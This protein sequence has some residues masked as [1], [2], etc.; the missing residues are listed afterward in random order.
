MGT[1][2]I[3][4][5]FEAMFPSLDCGLVQAIVSEAPAPERAMETLLALTAAMGEPVAGSEGSVDLDQGKPVP[6]NVHI[7]NH[8]QFPL[9]LSADGWQVVSQ[10]E[11]ERS[12]EEELGNAWLD[13]AKI[14]S[15]LPAQAVSQK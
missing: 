6:H 9:L 12:P 10:R 13:R 5:D 7:E 1:S 15:Q 8:E 11:L 2:A 3:T 4:G 14:A